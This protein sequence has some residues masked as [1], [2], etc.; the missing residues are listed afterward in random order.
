MSR[1]ARA[2][3]AS[4]VV[5]SAAASL[6]VRSG[7]LSEAGS[8]VAEAVAAGSQ[9]EGTSTDGT[10]TG[11]GAGAGAGAEAG[12]GAGAGAA[13]GNPMGSGVLGTQARAARSKRLT[14]H[15]RFGRT[16][17]PRRESR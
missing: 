9:T 7:P 14:G 10:A 8:G 16:R 2:R 11:D 4:L 12:A 5:S 15:L 3:P 6:I 1:A 13:A 17:A